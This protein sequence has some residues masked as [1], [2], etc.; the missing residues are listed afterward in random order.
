MNH[1]PNVNKLILVLSTLSF[2]QDNFKIYN[3]IIILL[4]KHGL[5]FELISNVTKGCYPL[6]FCAKYGWNWFSGSGVVENVNGL[7]RQYMIRKVHELSDMR[8]NQ[9]W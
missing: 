5:L 9:V 8:K 3:L 6:L 1:V 7:Q 4:E 2:V